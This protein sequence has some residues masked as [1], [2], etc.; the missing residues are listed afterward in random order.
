MRWARAVTAALLLGGLLLVV[1]DEVRLDLR[2]DTAQA[3]VVDTFIQ[4]RG[5]DGAVVRIPVGGQTVDARVEQPWFG[6]MPRTG[7]TI[8]VEYD[9]KNPS[10]ARRAGTHDLVAVGVPVLLAGVLGLTG[11]RRWRGSGPSRPK[12]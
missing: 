6:D 11:W 9:P 1:R 3:T 8:A 7:Q 12:R 2:H 10:R 5:P 4:Y